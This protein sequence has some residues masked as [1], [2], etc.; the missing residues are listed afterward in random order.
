V[1][2]GSNDPRC[3]S[4]GV[5]SRRDGA[6]VGRW[7][8]PTQRLV[9]LNNVAARSAVLTIVVACAAAL[10][11]CTS[12]PS[13][14]SADRPAAVRTSPAETAL[15]GS[16]ISSATPPR[17]TGVR[18]CRRHQLRVQFEEG[19]NATGQNF[20]TVLI[21]NIGATRCVMTG[22]VA[23]AAYYASRLRDNNTSVDRPRRPRSYILPPR[24]PRRM[25]QRPSR[26]YLAAVLMGADRDDPRRAN[27]I[28]A[29]RDER[30]PETLVVRIGSETLH[31]SNNGP[32][33]SYPQPN[34]P[35]QGAVYGC[36]GVIT[37]E[38]VSPATE[39]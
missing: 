12:H 4:F 38:S 2:R 36:H 34:S 11:S 20:G 8:Q 28:C 39:L 9:R 21:R 10:S 7:S 27:G 5:L 24:V 19:G 37:F 26:G 6:A 3:R 13:S 15:P 23:F 18:S 35:R 25:K 33:S 30:A 17:R 31:V 1:T 22:R 29:Y 16:L 32:R 14:R